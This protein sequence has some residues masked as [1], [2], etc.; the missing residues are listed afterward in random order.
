MF[1]LVLSINMLESTKSR[2]LYFSPSFFTA[3]L[4]F[5]PFDFSFIAF[6]YP[7]SCSRSPKSNQIPLKVASIVP[8]KAVVIKS[9]DRGKHEDSQLES[10]HDWLIGIRHVVGMIVVV[11]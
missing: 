6:Y 11:V 5:A 8:K 4:T 2:S 7:F 3:F 1:L 10:E 9:R